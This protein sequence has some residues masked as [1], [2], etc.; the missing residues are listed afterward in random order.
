M[1]Q[2]QVF[3]LDDDRAQPAQTSA[4][5]GLFVW[6]L[7]L[8][9]A[10]ATCLIL[11]FQP[12]Y[13]FEPATAGFLWAGVFLVGFAVGG[14]VRGQLAAAL[15]C[16]LFCWLATQAFTVISD[17]KPA[18]SLLLSSLNL[19]AGWLCAL[20]TTNYWSSLRERGE[21]DPASAI[22]R[23]VGRSQFGLWDIV[24]VTLLVAMVSSCTSAVASPMA[25]IACG[26]A[27]AVGGLISSWIA[28]RLAWHDEWKA[29]QV[30]AFSMVIVLA[31][32]VL[33]LRSPMPAWST[34]KWLIAGPASTI[35]AQGTTVL[36]FCAALRWD[37][38]YRRKLLLQS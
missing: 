19:M 38:S 18:E 21:D 12:P 37:L 20:S 15:V 30:I 9:P 7:C 34:I 33:V 22:S 23:P 17:F 28:S 11:G 35:A 32:L 24:F 1:T 13:A 36:F 27:A 31:V 16:G 6:V 25:L 26:V 14:L 10:V 4:P 3:P 29:T 5:S 8:L 2:L